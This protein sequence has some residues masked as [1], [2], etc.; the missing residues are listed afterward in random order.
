MWDARTGKNPFK[1]WASVVDCGDPVLTFLD[2][3]A[4]LRQLEK[5]HRRIAG[6]A[7]KSRFQSST[8]RIITLGGDHTTTLAALRSTYSKWG[9]VSVIH[10]DSHIGMGKAGTCSK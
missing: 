3:T 2:N 9:M 10:F 5:A 6:R 1:S 8:P 7:A 4:A